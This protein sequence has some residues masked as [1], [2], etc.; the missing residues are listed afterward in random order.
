MKTASILF[1]PLPLRAALLGLSLFAA[2]LHLARAADPNP[3]DRMTFQGFLTDGNGVALAPSAPKNFDVVFRIYDDQSAG[4]LLWAEQQTVTVDN[5]NFSVL[6]GEGSDFGEPRPALATL[7]TSNTA[8]DR[9]VQTTVKGIAS[10]GADATIL[11]R[12]RLLTSPYAYLAQH[13]VNAGRLVNDSHSQIVT[14]TGT[15]VGINKS[16]PAV[17][18]DVEGAAKVSGGLTV[19]GLTNTGVSRLEGDVTVV[20]KITASRS[21]ASTVNFSLD[22]S[23]YLTVKNISGGNNPAI[24]WDGNDWMAYRRAEN[25]FEFRIA[26]ATKLRI[27]S[28]KVIVDAPGGIEGRGTIP[29]GGI[30]MWSG[31]TVPTGWA[32]C[33]GQTVNSITTPDLKDR[34]I[35]GT[36]GTYA[37]GATGGSKEV[38]LTTTQLPAH[39]HSMQDYYHAETDNRGHPEYA[40]YIGGNWVGSGDSDT[41]NDYLFYKTHNTDSAGGGAAHENRPPYYALAFI[42]RVY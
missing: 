40:T 35:V 12:L 33:N 29:L 41:D 1:A 28:D 37:L 38:A 30:I 36:G 11:P 34:F 5:G 24:N 21:Y 27:N 23:A 7:F 6:L 32:L 19:N 22:G 39:S 9:F 31:A 10:G 13:A 16:S 3:P 25:E 17:T 26:T 2:G 4:T 15:S 42:M 20:D 8:S 18:L 14:V